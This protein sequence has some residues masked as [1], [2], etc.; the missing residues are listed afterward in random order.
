[1]SCKYE[2]CAKC[3]K[4]SKIKK[5]NTEITSHWKLPPSNYS[6]SDEMLWF[7]VFHFRKKVQKYSKVILSSLSVVFTFI[8]LT[9]RS[10][11][12]FRAVLILGNKKKSL[13]ARSAVYGLQRPLWFFSVNNCKNPEQISPKFFSFVY[14]FARRISQ[15]SINK[16]DATKSLTNNEIKSFQLITNA[17]KLSF[18]VLFSSD[19]VLNASGMR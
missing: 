9:C 1:M 16:S 7:R 13:E 6:T 11:F 14:I 4:K 10:R 18:Y 19:C 2:V 3:N 15:P 12:F 8:S 17:I 5:Y